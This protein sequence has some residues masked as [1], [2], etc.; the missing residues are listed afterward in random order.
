[1]QRCLEHADQAWD[2]MLRRY[3]NLI[4]S[5][6]LKVGLPPEEQEEAFQA[7]VVA[8]YRQ[9]PRLRQ[10]ERLLSWIIGIAWRQAVNR[11]RSRSRETRLEEVTDP[12]M[13]HAID[14]PAAGPLPDEERLALARSQQLLEALEQLSERCQRLLGYLF[15]EDP[16]PDYQE[17]SRR[18]KIPIG[19]L[20]P[21]R[22][23]CLDKLRK[24]FQDRGWPS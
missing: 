2:E 1:M 22:A 8:I 14:R 7:T 12:I 11:I 15:F 13:A 20:G 9:L 24:L 3:S 10:P 5:T 23:R 4:Y 21:T 6:I 18:E 17:I 16:A 19:S